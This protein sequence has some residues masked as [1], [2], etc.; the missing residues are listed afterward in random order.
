MSGTKYVVFLIQFLDAIN[1]AIPIF[2]QFYFILF[3]DGR[4]KEE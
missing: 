1:H 4:R 3:C 2:I